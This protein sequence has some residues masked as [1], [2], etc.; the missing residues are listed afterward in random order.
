MNNIKRSITE[1]E[2]DKE[3]YYKLNGKAYYLNSEQCEVTEIIADCNNLAILK[4]TLSK[5]PNISY[6]FT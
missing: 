6:K 4:K 1:L 3:N 5:S 2:N